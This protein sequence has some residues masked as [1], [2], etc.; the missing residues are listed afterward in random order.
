[1]KANLKFRT[2]MRRGYEKVRME[3][4]LLFMLHNG[5]RMARATI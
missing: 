2:V 4:A 5:M 3:M 1:M